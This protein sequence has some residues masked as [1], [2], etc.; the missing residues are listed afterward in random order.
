MKS[1]ILK[2]LIEIETNNDVKVIY[3]CES[4]SRAWGFA[5]ED[6]D[7][8]VRFIYVHSKDWYL[9]IA[10]K[11]D[12]I[13]IPFDGELDING[14]DI[15]KSLKLLRKSNSPLIEWLSSPIKYRNVRSAMNSLVELSAD[16]FL[17]ETSCHHYLSMTQNIIDN[18]KEGEEVSVKSYLYSLRT[19]LCCRWIINRL[20]QPPM[21]I[22]DL[23]NEFLPSGELRQ[24][25]DKLIDLKIKGA[26]SANINR[27]LFFEEYLESQLNFV[28]SKIP[29]NP[30]KIPIERFDSV[31]RKILS[32]SKT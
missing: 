30:K 4:G 22:Q 8:D 31:F 5:S 16:A 14:W 2:E 26:E 1:Q 19:I 20:N 24:L 17:P 27:T 10:D 18:F 7:Y 29:K 12:I 32:E 13:E 11:R 9:T 25:V 23:L 6:S 3:A 15:R 21:Q 28:E